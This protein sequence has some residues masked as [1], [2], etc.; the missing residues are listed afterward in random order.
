[1]IHRGQS[2][3]SPEEKLDYLR[4]HVR[5]DGDCLLWAGALTVRGYP[6]TVWRREAYLARRLLLQLAGRPMHDGWCVW[7]TCG[8]KTC[9]NE[10]H[11]RAG[12]RK[13]MIRAAARAGCMLSGPR[14]SLVVAISRAR[15]AKLPITQAAT[16]YRLRAQGE[17][18]AAIGARY[19][20]T[21]DAVHKAMKAWKRAG[22]NEWTAREA[23]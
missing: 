15:Q 5:R 6:R 22:I 7:A 23:A 20:V 3:H 18:L 11:L 9:M 12:S 21:A 19:G 1:M 17:T 13:Q 2:P 16:V 14:R 10:A 4:T 8:S